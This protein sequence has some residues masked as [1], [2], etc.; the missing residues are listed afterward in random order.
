LDNVTVSGV[1]V[2]NF[3]LLAATSAAVS[4]APLSPKRPLGAIPST[5]VSNK[6]LLDAQKPLPQASP[7]FRGSREDPLLTATKKATAEPINTADNS[8]AQDRNVN[9]RRSSSEHAVQ[10]AI[11]RNSNNSSSS[12][13]SSS[14]GDPTPIARQAQEAWVQQ[15]VTTRSM[16]A[17]L[18]IRARPLH[19]TAPQLLHAVAANDH[20]AIEEAY[21]ATE[22]SGLRAALTAD[23]HGCTALHV[24]ALRGASLVRL[25]MLRW[26]HDQVSACFHL[27]QI[28]K[29]LYE[30]VAVFLLQLYSKQD[31]YDLASP[32][33]EV[34]G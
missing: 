12:S 29:R 2:A 6:S 33:C 25:L 26:R 17:D 16:V 8:D 7:T 10:P 14:R 13:S 22:L 18:C 24:A 32:H 20:Q 9:R 23:A 27:Q 15:Q 31:S 4:M 28:S 5:A 21:A 30:V 34:T 3:L 11:R 1:T 19:S